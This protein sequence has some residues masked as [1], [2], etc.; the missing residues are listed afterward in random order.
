M[1]KGDIVKTWR[2]K[3]GDKYTKL[4]GI[5]ALHDFLIVRDPATNNAIMKVRK[6]CYKDA[7]KET[8][9]KIVSSRLA[10]ERGY[11]FK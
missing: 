11:S 5:Q 1:M 6:Q 9:M 10:S 8:S 3:V 7:F 2:D 4:P